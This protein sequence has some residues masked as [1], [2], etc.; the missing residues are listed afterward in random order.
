MAVFKLP[1]LGEG[2]TE[3]EIVAW[4]VAVGDTV[5]VDQ[6]VVEVETA[7]ASVEVPVPFA[8]RVATLHGAAG[9]T[10]AVGTPL[11]TVEEGAFVEPGV[12]T[13][14]PSE[15]SGNVLIGY[16]TGTTRARR[17]RRPRGAARPAV[18]A[19]PKSAQDR[20]RVVSP[21]VRRLAKESGVDI[22]TLTGSGTGG[23]IS[24]ADVERA[25]AAPATAP[26][27]VADTG[28]YR[29]PLRGIRKTVADK[30]TRSRRE[31]PEATVWVDVDATPLLELRAA[32]NADPSAPKVSLLA[33]LSRFALAGL[34]RFPE[35]N[36]RIEG[37]EIVVPSAVQLGF[38]AQTDRGLVVP[39]V[40]D[41]HALT[42]EELSAALAERTERA[43]AGKL[44]PAELTGGSFTINNYGVFGVDG[45]A[46]IINHPEVA[47]LGI[48]RI[49]DRPWIVEGQV[50]PR[51]ITEL[52]LA[53][54]HRACD[55]GTAGGFLRFVAD[56]VESPLRLLRNV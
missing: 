22:R 52:T 44:A 38:A 39:V 3:A 27:A 12:V 30:L 51:K 49:I 48:G 7:K 26:V 10:L 32:L 16:G 40:P 19:A 2:L 36:S 25:A 53:F 33:L 55:G 35:L 42:V 20:I 13:P 8:G 9:D 11:I 54:D 56:C 5:T 24:R 18:H 23:L 4:H 21:L 47:I 43:R 1:D 46:A 50:V 6:T 29:I 31:I 45:S 41:A 17:M 15:G 34:R 28:E 14:A 37:D